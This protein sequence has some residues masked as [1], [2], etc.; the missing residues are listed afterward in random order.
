M[1]CLA[2]FR[3]RLYNL[4]WTDG[5]TG[6]DMQICLSTGYQGAVL[7]RWEVRMVFYIGS[8]HAI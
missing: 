6:M 4:L 3:S 1:Q 8:M 5:T 2:G 7:M